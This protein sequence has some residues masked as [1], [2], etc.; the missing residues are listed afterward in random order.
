MGSEA[1][2]DD[3]RLMLAALLDA[4]VTDTEL[5][6]ESEWLAIMNRALAS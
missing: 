2:N 4:G 1:T 3:A 5:V 6:S